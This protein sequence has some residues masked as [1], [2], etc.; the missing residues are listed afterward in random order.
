MTVTVADLIGIMEQIAPPGLAEEWD[1]SGLQI[2]RRDWPI[3]RVWVSL[4]PTPAVVSAACAAAVDL[5]VTHHPLIFRAP[6][7]IDFDTPFGRIVEQAV[8]RR[9]SIYSAHTNLDITAGGINDILAERLSLTEL[10]LLQSTSA[11]G[12]EGIGRVGTLGRPMPLASL[13][14]SIKE[15]A[16]LA[17]VRFSGDPDLPVRRLAVCS[18]GGSGLMRAFFASA[19]DAYVSGDLKYHDARDV[20]AAGRGLIDIGHFASEHL[21]VDI[22]AKRLKTMLATMSP[23]VDVAACTLER[24]PFIVL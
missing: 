2:G 22:L 18:G 5:L 9:L 23:P 13:A 11:D 6:K 12:K 8:R 1:N 19:A 24:D 3:R 15:T 14:R 21:I 10:V 17:T 4:D 20:E 7:S 16:G